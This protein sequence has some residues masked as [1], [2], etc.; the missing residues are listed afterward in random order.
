[1]LLG[2]GQWIGAGVAPQFGRD[3]LDGGRIVACDN[4]HACNTPI[5]NVVRI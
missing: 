4:E 2:D 1:M 5:P 3:D